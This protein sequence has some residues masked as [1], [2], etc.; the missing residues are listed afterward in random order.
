MQNKYLYEYALIR[1][2]PCV[3]REEFI[4]VGVVVLCANKNFLQTVISLDESRLAC[5]KLHTDLDQIRSY[6]NNFNAIAQGKSDSGPIGL[7]SLAARFRWL[8]ANR[9]TVIQTSRVH[10]GLTSDPE[11][12]LQ[13]LFQE[14]VSL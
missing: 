2:V 4:N 3:E 9:S 8:T 11:K 6:L 7:L 10:P 14:L 13:R 12:T 1:I 5:L